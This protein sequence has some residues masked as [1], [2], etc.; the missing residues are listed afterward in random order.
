MFRAVNLNEFSN[1]A[2][3]TVSLIDR[4]SILYRRSNRELVL[5]CDCVGDC[6]AGS[7]NVVYLR[8]DMRWQDDQPV[9]EAERDVIA[10]DII[11]A[12]RAVGIET[13]VVG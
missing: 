3:V 10:R 5:P 9:A 1:D 7:G 2:G 8:R 4:N 6:D 12:Y 13:E 11:D